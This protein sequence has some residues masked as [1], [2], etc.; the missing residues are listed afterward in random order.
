[1]DNKI[2]IE[3]KA[4]LIRVNRLFREGMSDG[5]LYEITRGIWKLGS[6]R[7][8]EVDY[9]FAIY[10]GVVQEVYEVVRWFPAGTL[11]YT[12]RIMKASMSPTSFEGRW[13]FEGRVADDTIRN[14]YVGQSVKHFFKFGASNPIMYVNC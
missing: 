4:L 3:E 8:E 10:Q 1:M 9:A 7:R 2:H 6:K 5:E 12:Y 13:E 11:E 14:K